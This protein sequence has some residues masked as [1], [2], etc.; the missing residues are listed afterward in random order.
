ML[1]RITRRRAPPLKRPSGAASATV[2][3][4]VAPWGITT[5]PLTATGWATVALNESPLLLILEPTA[6]PR[7]TVI[8]WPAGISATAGVLAAS[9]PLAAPPL[10]AA[11][12]PLLAADSVAACE[13]DA[14]LEFED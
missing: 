2:P 11:L 1:L 3:E 6:W 8:A 7:R 5:W 14:S 9:L 12:S 10:G 13:L 4:A